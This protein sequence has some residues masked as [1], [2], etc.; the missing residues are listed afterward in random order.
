MPH[1]KKLEQKNNKTK[2][3]KKKRETK[4]AEKVGQIE[5][6]SKQ[7]EKKAKKKT[8]ENEE[9]KY[10]CELVFNDDQLEKD[11]FSY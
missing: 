1:D 9:A 8:N 11:P 2:N 10:R 7:H 5:K 4:F 6:E 3:G